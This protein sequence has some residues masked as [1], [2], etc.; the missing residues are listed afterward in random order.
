MNMVI[1]AFIRKELLQTL[2]DPRMFA[3]VFVMP[4]VQLA[5]FGFALSTEIK[6][7]TISFVSSPHD[8]RMNEIARDVFGSGWFIAAN[9]SNVDP[10]DAIKDNEANVIVIAPAEGLTRT[11]G[12]GRGEV[13]ALI[14][15]T[16]VVRAQGIERYLNAFI[17]SDSHIGQSNLIETRVLYNPA[18][19]SRI[20]MVPGVLCMVMT[21]LSVVLT[22][23]GMA[24]ERESGT[25]ETI[26][27][28]PVARWEIILGKTLPYFLLALS[29]VPIVLL[30]AVFL[31]DLPVRGPLIALAL[32][33]VV[34]VAAM[35]SIGMAISTLA[36]TQQQGMLGALLFLF[37]SVM[38]SGIAFPID[39]MPIILKVIAWSHPLT[40]FAALLRNILLKGG[41]WPL[42]IKYTSIITLMALVAMTVAIRRFKKTIS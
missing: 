42:I 38:L 12:K 10:Y 37:P 24:K 39:N 36:K 22:S 31:F 11:S 9:R 26:I 27:G 18:L 23:M 2:R 32:A 5:V 8:S 16:N 28:A 14:D 17:S 19:E 4:L 20:F 25:F 7:V 41:S 30:G 34:Y 29:T 6:N 33:S 21:V 40:Y 1:I 35:V 3:V 15:G 13:Q